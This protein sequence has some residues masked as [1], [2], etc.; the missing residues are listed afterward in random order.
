MYFAIIETELFIQIHCSFS[1]VELT[2]IAFS[3]KPEIRWEIH[4]ANS[5]LTVEHKIRTIFNLL[6][7]AGVNRTNFE[8]L[9]ENR[10]GMLEAELH[11]YEW[12]V[13]ESPRTHPLRLVYRA[14]SLIKDKLKI[15]HRRK[16]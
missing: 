7:A 5:I 9:Y 12:I 11:S 16:Q 1:K 2:S 15:Q 3:G 6:L 4:L 10:I 14:L 13:E 8:V